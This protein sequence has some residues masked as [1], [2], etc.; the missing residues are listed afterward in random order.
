[1]FSLIHTLAHVDATQHAPHGLTLGLLLT[2][3]ARCLPAHPRTRPCGC[4]G[5][6]PTAHPAACRQPAGRGPAACRHACLAHRSCM[7]GVRGC[8]HHARGARRA[9]CLPRPFPAWKLRP[10]WPGPVSRL[11][12][13]STACPAAPDRACPS[14]RRVGGLR[15]PT[16]PPHGMLD[17]DSMPPATTTWLAPS[18]MDCAPSIM[19]FRPAALVPA[20]AGRAPSTGW[21]WVR[22][23]GTHA[24][25]MVSTPR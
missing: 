16:L 18:M 14:S 10:S 4:C 3:L 5:R 22:Q 7:Q 8:K 19:A 6:H 1:M 12:S 25:R 23:R 13:A 17:I 24:Q 21:A 11:H 2:H 9:G 15:P 20:R